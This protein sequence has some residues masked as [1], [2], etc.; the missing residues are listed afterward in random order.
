VRAFW[1]FLTR[2]RRLPTEPVYS[3]DT[4]T[5]IRQLIACPE[6]GQY[7]LLLDIKVSETFAGLLSTESD[8]HV[9][10]LRGYAQ[11]LL[12]SV[13]VP[14]DIINRIDNATARTDR[15]AEHSARVSASNRA[16]LL[17]TSLYTG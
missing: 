16:A 7:K 11:G 5:A 9:H 17:N 3:A 4:L 12:N 2:K 1:R 10:Y 14:E 13:Q 6:W 15:I 8:S